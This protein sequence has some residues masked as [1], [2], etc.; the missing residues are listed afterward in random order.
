MSEKYY[1]VG[2]IVNTH[3]IKGEV[4]VIA[5]TDFIEDRFRPGRRLYIFLEGTN[6]PIEVVI[7]TSRPHKQFQVI[8]FEGYPTI[9]EVE[10]F[11]GGLLKIKDEDR[12]PLAEG[13]YYYDEIIGLEVWTEEGEQLGIVKEIFQTGAN[14][15][16]VVKR[17]N[18]PDLLLPYIGD[19][20]KQVDL[21]QK[22]IIVHLLE[23]LE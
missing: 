17:E 20:V 7:K 4:R 11:K 12:G 18:K 16:W 9:N 3:G 1:N 19:C 10:K 8:S 14:D 2:K 6:S 13:E 21:E 5:M 23:G 15:V 22:K